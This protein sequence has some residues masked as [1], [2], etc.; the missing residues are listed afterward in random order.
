MESRGEVLQKWVKRGVVSVGAAT[1]LWLIMRD[2][3]RRLH[4]L[5]R[6]SPR[7]VLVH[8]LEALRVTRLAGFFES[9]RVASYSLLLLLGLAGAT[10]GRTLW[11]SLRHVVLDGELAPSDALAEYPGPRRS[12][13]RRARRLAGEPADGENEEDDDNDD[14]G[15][16]DEDDDE[17]DEEDDEDDDEEDGDDAGGEAI[18]DADEG[19]AGARRGALPAR[20]TSGQRRASVT[21]ATAAASSAVAAGP[22]AGAHMRHANTASVMPSAGSAGNLSGMARPRAPT[23]LSREASSPELSA[24]GAGA[25][26]ASPAFAQGSAVGP[27]AEALAELGPAGVGFLLELQAT[28][29]GLDVDVMLAL[30]HH[31]ETITL[32]PGE[33][34]FRRGGDVDEGLYV[35]MEGALEVIDD[36]SVAAGAGFGRPDGTDGAQRQAAPG[37]VPLSSAVTGARRGGSERASRAAVAAAWQLPTDAAGLAVAAAI[38]APGIEAHRRMQLRDAAPIAGRQ[39]GAMDSTV[40]AGASARGGAGVSAGRGGAW[41]HGYRGPS[42]GLGGQPQTV[43]DMWVQRRRL[44]EAARREGVLAT[45]RRAQTLGENALLAGPGETRAATVRA[46]PQHRRGARGDGRTRVLRMSRDTFNWVVRTF[47]HAAASFVLSTTARQWRVAHLALVDF[48]SLPEA[49]ALEREPRIRPSRDRSASDVRAW[50]R[51][52]DAAAWGL[53]LCCGLGHDDERLAFRAGQVSEQLR[54]GAAWEV[55]AGLTAPGSRVGAGEEQWRTGAADSPSGGGGKRTGDEMYDSE[56]EGE[57]EGGD[58]SAAMSESEMFADLD[59]G[60]STAAPARTATPPVTGARAGWAGGS[61]AP[62]G[63]RRPSHPGTEEEEDDA[64]AAR[65]ERGEDV[66]PAAAAAQSPWAAR[67]NREC[68]APLDAIAFRLSD[69]DAAGAPG[70]GASFVG[71]SPAGLAG[72]GRWPKSAALLPGVQGAG[73]SPRVDTGA[74]A[75]SQESGA[76]PAAQQDSVE[77]IASAAASIV[78]LQ[79]GDVLYREGADGSSPSDEPAAASAGGAASASPTSSA[80][81]RAGACYVLLAGRAAALVAMPDEDGQ[82]ALRPSRSGARQAASGPGGDFSRQSSL[83]GASGARR[84]PLSRSGRASGG[85]VQAAPGEFLPT[86]HR[87]VR[88]VLPGDIIGGMACVCEVPHRET[89]VALGECAFAVF[90]RDLL[91]AAAAP[92]VQPVEQ[93]RDGDGSPQDGAEGGPD[94][95]ARPSPAIGHGLTPLDPERHAVVLSLLL[96][97]AKLLRPLLRLF[98]SLGLKR[99]WR[100]AG[101]I[102]FR[103]GEPCDRG[104]Y[105]VVSGRVRVHG[106]QQRDGS[107]GD[108]ASSTAPGARGGAGARGGVDSERWHGSGQFGQAMHEAS[109]GATVGELSVLA[110]HAT[111]ASTAVCVRDTELVSVSRAALTRILASHP[112]VMGRFARAL[113]QRQLRLRQALAM[114]ASGAGMPTSG[115]PFHLHSSLNGPPPG[116]LSQMQSAGAMGASETDGLGRGCVAVLPAGRGGRPL[117]QFGVWLA[118]ELGASSVAPTRCITA[119]E[120]D[121]A[122]GKG[123]STRMTRVLERARVAAW[124]SRQEEVH[125]FVVLVGDTTPTAWSRLVAQHADVVLL[126][127]RGARGESQAQRAAALGAVEADAVFT[128]PSHRGSGHRRSPGAHGRGGRPSTSLAVAGTAVGEALHVIA[129]AA[130]TITRRAG[131]AIAGRGLASPRPGH[132]GDRVLR[133]RDDALPPP[134][135]RCCRAGRR[136]GGAQPGD[137]DEATGVRTLARIELVLLWEDGGRLPEQTR[138]WL[139]RR[140]LAAHHHVREADAPWLQSGARAPSSGSQTLQASSAAS[141]ASDAASASTAPSR[142]TAQNGGTLLRGTAPGDNGVARIARFLSGRAVGVVMGGGG[143]RGLAHLGVLRALRH[144]GIPVDFIAGTSQGA[145]MAAS[146]ASTLDLA[147]A[148]RAA[149]VMAARVGSMWVLLQGL[150]LPLISY[151]DGQTFSEAI[152]DA[153]GPAAQVEDLWLPFF[154]VTTNIT[155]ARMDIHQAGPLWRCIRASMTVLGLLP[156][157]LDHSRKHL[158]ADG[159]YLD[160]LAVGVMASLAPPAGLRAIVAVDVENKESGRPLENVEDYGEGLSGWWLL[161]R[162]VLAAVGV[163]PKVRIPSMSHVSLNLSYISHSIRIRQLLSAAARRAGRTAPVGNAESASVVALGGDGGLLGGSSALLYM[164]PGVGH[165]GL[166]DYDK[167][168]EISSRGRIEADAVLRDWLEQTGERPC[169]FVADMPEPAPATEAGEEF[170]VVN[171][172]A[173]GDDV[174]S[175][176]PPVGPRPSHRRVFSDSMAPAPAPRDTDSPPLGLQLSGG[177]SSAVPAAATRERA[178]SETEP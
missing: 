141:V 94:D 79:P 36:E 107:G 121:S 97:C 173:L 61:S 14:E 48:L 63:G 96:R 178:S 117:R 172:P 50:L 171:R 1:L 131:E 89:V 120:V 13:G 2:R 165:Y 73:G 7:E 153:L 49:V 177:H 142:A 136:G 166:L 87:I 151:F 133:M 170:D 28:A 159:G 68:A 104:L 31:L 138:K 152:Q 137:D 148:S 113:A 123:T 150:T 18:D 23:A 156:P 119:D 33:V 11:S 130:E 82:A 64:T 71:R 140:R 145:F 100:H 55:A 66:F 72:L 146:W 98:L 77:A 74:A 101:G 132:D 57:G 39:A 109:R 135:R 122:L 45:F 129:G 69:S 95:G 6:R 59:E 105:L 91:E 38:A 110:G 174:P 118:R 54:N 162:W 52:A 27:R 114:S 164:R 46:T 41:A 81:F 88:H 126:L 65:A 85:C 15:E 24:P 5:R 167:I 124:L 168:K 90:P 160:N 161:Y 42:A 76:Q 143:A 21:A 108:D 37:T 75:A 125:A 147:G 44:A 80:S 22:G 155:A 139:R 56:G 12:P 116:P 83:R 58:S 19:G 47:P 8:V 29:A 84:T 25:D 40:G 169:L 154:C 103:A 134:E 26:P 163:G 127:G 93:S 9:N 67:W 112:S 10:Y 157:I 17:D 4:G 3:S 20:L 32:E 176:R 51:R 92:P 111:R 62:L 106:A 70:R 34:L 60:G 175:A 115:M 128:T 53:L 158:L 35:V 144:R 149:N 16:D 99:A 86:S 30:R 43:A 102:L 78:R